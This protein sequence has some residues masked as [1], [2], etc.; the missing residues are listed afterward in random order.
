M[1]SA[2]PVNYEVFNWVQPGPTQRNP[3]PITRPGIAEI[4]PH[5]PTGIA[6][7]ERQLRRRKAPPGRQRWLLTYVVVSQPSSGKAGRAR[8]LAYHV[9]PTGKNGPWDLG[10][11]VIPDKIPFPHPRNPAFFGMAIEPIVRQQFKGWLPGGST[12]RRG[13]GGARRGVDVK[14]NELAQYYAELASE[15]GDPFF[16]VLAAELTEIAAA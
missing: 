7:G 1:T 8:V 4:K 10:D 9:T 2:P 14:W 15:T 12:L 6:A 16:E 11:A 3:P 5:T 13:T